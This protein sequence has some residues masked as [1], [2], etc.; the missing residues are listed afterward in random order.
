M[1]NKLMQVASFSGGR[2]SAFLCSLLLESFPRERLRFVF[3]DT[4]AEHPAT[5]DFIR[6]VNE[7]FEL[8]LVCLR[9]DSSLPLGKGV[10]PYVVSIDDI[11][12]DLIPYRDLAAKY[13]TP[14]VATPWCT[15][16]L[17]E[18][19]HD[20]WCDAELGRNNYVTWIGVR[21]DEPK[22]L[23]GVGK[24][25][26]KRYLAELDDADK[27]DVLAY[28]RDM[29]FDL[30]IP[31]HL[32]NCVFCVK[33]SQAKLALACRD[34]PLMASQWMQMLDESPNRTKRPPMTSES[35][36]RGKRRLQS[37]IEEYEDVPTEVLRG[38][39]RSSRNDANT[40]AESCEVFVGDMQ[41]SLFEM[42]L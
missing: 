4:G 28:W 23:G 24:S 13:G 16:R 34:E 5:Y 9:C 38:R 37:I 22:R 26:L 1:S 11:G 19:V 39:I 33:K 42:S 21:A 40:C 25:P 32:G 8:D 7:H 12:P 35:V 41:L 14:T 2:T 36:Y 30:Q 17:K 29:P 15:S 20:K 3:M 27:Q 6:E 10:R 31:E 18:I